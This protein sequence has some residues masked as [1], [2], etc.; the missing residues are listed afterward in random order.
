[1]SIARSSR[2]VGPRT[3]AP[4]GPLDPRDHA[5]RTDLAELSLASLVAVP[6]YI[7]PMPMEASRQ[8]MVLADPRGAPRAVSEL[9]PGEQFAVLDTAHGFAWGYS[10]ADH[11][12]GYVPLDALTE[13][14]AGV[15][16]RIGPGDALLFREPSIK[17]EVVATLPAGALVYPHAGPQAPFVQLAE[18]VGAGLFVHQRHLLATSNNS[19]WIE[20]AMGFLGA[21]YRWGGRSR[22]GI[23]CSG[24]VQLARQLAGHACR[25]DSDMIFADA[26]L[27]IPAEEAGRGDLVWW[28]GHIGLLVDSATILHANAHFMSCVVEPLS[29][30]VARLDLPPCCKRL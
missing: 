10:V 22:M 23:D 11:Y 4:L 9:L 3:F 29:D 21:P 16:Q 20:I 30:V 25:R 5:W 14:A 8:T 17:A 18:G 2:I 15:A 6:N 19:D 24:L 12:V 7:E 27:E 1:M 13:P 28:P 26:P